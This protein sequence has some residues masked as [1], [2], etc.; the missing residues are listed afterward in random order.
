VFALLAIGVVLVGYAL[1]G[2]LGAGLAAVLL[3]LF[4]SYV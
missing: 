1:G 4:L 2:V 3:F